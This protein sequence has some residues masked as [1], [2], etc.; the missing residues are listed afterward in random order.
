PMYKKNTHIQF[1][2]IGGI[3]MSGLA[4]ILKQSGYTVSGCD[5][6]TSQETVTQLEKLGCRIHQGNNA[7]EC[8]DN[9]INILVYIPMYETT[10]KS[11]T[12]EI[13]HARN[14]G[15]LT[16]TRAQ[17]LAELMRTKFSIAVAGSHGKT[18]TSALI[19]HILISA[20]LDP[21][22]VI[23]GQLKNITSNAHLG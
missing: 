7:P 18:T 5:S 12:N 19:S 21:T 16:I 8:A 22:I 11:I 20:D 17:M 3:G 13:S 4:T 2:G 9:N 23:G 15:I 10:I 1:V 14:A 6:D